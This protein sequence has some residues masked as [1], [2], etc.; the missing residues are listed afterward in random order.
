M[1]LVPSALASALRSGWLVPD[2]G[3]FPDSTAASADAFAAAVAGWFGA[4]T[5]G[6]FPCATAAVRRPQLAGAATPALAAGAA[7]A[8]GGQLT[9][10]L[11]GYLAGQAFGPGVAAPP[12]AA[13]AAQADLTAVFADLGMAPNTRADRI[14]AAVHTL[15]TSSVVTFPPV[16]SPPAPVT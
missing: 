13:A 7:A 16:V 5:A 12:V 15:A 14:A 8:A 1:V 4:A 11:V 6:A 3:R 9:L 2:G 10:A